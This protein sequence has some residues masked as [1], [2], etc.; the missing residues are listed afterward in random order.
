MNPKRLKVI[1]ACSVIITDS[2]QIQGTLFFEAG[3][4]AGPVE[5]MITTTNLPV[6]AK[7]SFNCPAPGPQPPIY[8]MPTVVSTHPRFT[9]GIT[10]NIPANFSGTIQYHAV[11]APGSP[12][13]Q[14]A[15]IALQAARAVSV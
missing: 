8:L 11:S 15:E 3:E 2:S 14:G 13:P 6:G 12:I 4:N 5:F 10:C 1:N 7:I 9:T